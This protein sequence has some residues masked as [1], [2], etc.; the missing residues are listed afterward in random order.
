MDKLAA[1]WSVVKRV[2]ERH[3]VPFAIFLLVIYLVQHVV[4]DTLTR[5]IKISLSLAQQ[6]AGKTAGIYLAIYL[7]AQLLR[8]FIPS[9]SSRA[10]SDRWLL[11]CL[12][13]GVLANSFN[14]VLVLVIGTQLAFYLRQIWRENEKLQ[15]WW[16]AR[17]DRVQSTMILL[18]A[19]VAGAVLLWAGW[20][21]S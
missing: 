5:D 11:A 18:L 15:T 12:V 10:S 6:I 4:V 19:L 1:V 16:A 14:V 2:I 8:S 9:A 21:A 13:V 20:V 3:V 17:G 7:L